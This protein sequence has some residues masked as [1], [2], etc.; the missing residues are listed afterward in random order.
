MSTTSRAVPSVRPAPIVD[1]PFAKRFV[2]A[3]GLVP[4]ILL[5]WDA[6]R[7]Q[8]GV[9]DVNFAI[10]TTGLLGLVF[11]TLSLVITPLRRLTGWTTLISVRRNLGVFGFVYIAAHFAIF[12]FYDRDMSVTS[13][14]EE[15]TERVYL[16]FGTGALV[17]MIPLAFTSTNAMVTRIGAKRWKLLHRTAY[18]VVLGGVIHYYL[19]VKAD[20]TMP[21]IFAGLFGGLMVY[22]LVGHYV[23]LR[24]EVT[25]A[26]ARLL[27]ARTSSGVAKRKFWSGQ[28]EVARI[29]QETPDVKTFR[30]VTPERRALPF[31][32]TAGQYLNIT[33]LIGGVRVRRSYTIASSPARSG[34]CEISVKRVADGY[35]SHHLHDTVKEGDRI[36]I[37]APAGRFV[38]A[39][40]EANRVV[41]VAGGVG[42]TPMISVVRSLT[43]RCWT[44]EI[45]LLFSVRKKTDIVFE[46][47]LDQLQARF[48]NL[49][50]CI[51]LSGD[52]D[53]AWTGARGHITRELVEGFVPELR[54]GP[55]LVCGPAPM[56]TA[57]RTLFVGIGVPDAEVLEEA[58]VSPP[59]P[60]ASDANVAA[61]AEV[62]DDAVAESAPTVEF[63][64]ANRTAELTAG[65]TVLE[66]A[67]DAGVSIPFE[68][69]S[70]ICGQC[71]TKLVS[72]R[73]TMDVQD[74]L[75][76]SDKAN[77]LILACQA[78]PT[79]NCVVDA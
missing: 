24:G 8:L 1:G 15:I 9:N 12:F 54:R 4:G 39:G 30:F 6:Y 67:E 69:R 49:H 58:F 64:R 77:G 55:V 21:L 56:M 7:G 74:A 5:L 63:Q 35:A 13:T 19:L 47:E 44:G 16:W 45:Y 34:Y 60:T 68:C 11:L 41:L 52:P 50:V 71:K 48:P 75:T 78:R 40:D 31:E 73:V 57:M 72:G 27:I 18:L 42:I 25:R 14:L 20:V 62:A 10:R 66:S 26:H 17:L 59:T 28:L 61:I 23:D 22:R 3:C 70:G 37:S 38:F 53:A 36:D 65:L 2:I 32:H 33:L 76:A 51:A 46:H 79:R 43:D 29:F